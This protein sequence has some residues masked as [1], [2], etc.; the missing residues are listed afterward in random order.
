MAAQKRLRKIQIPLRVFALPSPRIGSIESNSGYGAPQIGQEIHQIVQKKRLRELQNYTPEKKMVW[1][2]SRSPYLFV[3]SGRADGIV[4]NLS[5]TLIE[6][7]KSSF[8]V[9]E[10]YHKLGECA[11]HPYVWQLRT[12][13]YIHY[14]QTGQTPSLRL[15]LVSSR[16]FAS[17]DLDVELD[18]EKYEIWLESRLTE[19]VEETKIKEKIFKKRRETA[20]ELKFPFPAPRPGQKELIETI[21]QNFVFEKPLMLQA[22]TGL[23]KTVGVLYPSL[24]EALARGQKVVYVTPKNSQHLVAEEAVEH[25]QESGADIKSLTLTAK[26]KMCLKAEPLCNPR[27]CEFAKDYYKKVQENDLLNKISKSRSLSSRKLREWGEKFQVCP[28]ELSVEAI[29]RADVVIAD[30][31]YVFA[32]RSLLGRLTEPLLETDEKPNL[33][34]DEAH[35]LPARAQDYFSPALSTLELRALEQQLMTLPLHFARAGQ[36]LA[37]EAQTLITQ[38]GLRGDSRK[39]EIDAEMFLDLDK[40]IRDFT[41]SYL[42]SDVDILPQDP[43]LKFSNLW[44]NF[45]EALAFSGEEFFQTYQKNPSHDLLKIT[46][47]DASAHLE[48]TYKSFKNVVA[49]SATL[50]PFHFYHALLGLPRDKSSAIEFSSPFPPEHR[51]LLVIPQISTRYRERQQN[52]PKIISV[53]EKVMA[54][55]PGNYIALLP[56]FEFMRSIENSLRSDGNYDLLT[57]QRDMKSPQ[58]AEYLERLRLAERPSLLL[59][60]QGGLFSEG[61]DFPG[62]MLIGAFVI[63]PALP[64]FDFEKEEI[65]AYYEKKYGKENGFNYVYAYPAMAKTVQSAGRVIRSE[66]DKGVIILMDSRFL[67]PVYFESMPQGWFEKSPQELVSQQILEDLRL[68]WERTTADTER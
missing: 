37:Q 17:R 39:I 16:N 24:R 49:F 7:I 26:A 31:N 9:D 57:Q 46:C 13:G 14:K 52:I 20:A 62:D 27:Y 45:I 40:K 15:H 34:V 59:G 44:G 33:V 19:L 55:R 11:D 36:K 22:P 5:E 63:G 47:C 64:N 32:P 21:E 23:G 2:F 1:E 42:E 60:V 28:F 35:N 41:T 10:L 8:D 25:L 58:V 29:D 65:R 66:K 6:E 51:K 48:E 54:L 3:I 56:S 61:V 53:I 4:E 38:H 30:Y 18:L 68:F 67:Q 43:A 50:K 12:Y